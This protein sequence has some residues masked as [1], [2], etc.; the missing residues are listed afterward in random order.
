MKSIYELVSRNLILGLLA[1]GAVALTSNDAPAAFSLSLPGYTETVNCRPDATGFPK[2]HF[3]NNWNGT[4]TVW[5]DSRTLGGDTNW[6]YASKGAVNGSVNCGQWVNGSVAGG[7]G[8][9]PGVASVPKGVTPNIN[10]SWYDFNW[11]NFRTGAGCGHQHLA[12]YVWGW[13]YN[14]TS[15]SFEFRSSTSTSTYIKPDGSCDFKGTG[16]PDFGNPDITGNAY[17]TGIVSIPNSPYAVL[18]TKHQ[19]TSHAG[20]PCGEF[21]CYHPILAMVWY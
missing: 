6:N 20:Y 1:G 9:V 18:Y 15:W 14:G 10:T 3:G 8:Y 19:A 7:A 16:N 12:T 5:L 2:I 11:P 13:R 21:G 4:N 17:G